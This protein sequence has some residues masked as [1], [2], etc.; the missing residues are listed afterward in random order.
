MQIPFGEI[1]ET[2]GR[3]QPYRI[4]YNSTK[5]KVMSLGEEFCD[6]YGKDCHVVRKDMENQQEN[7]NVCKYIQERKNS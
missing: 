1:Q 6:N 3:Q 7:G 2:L 5:F 4:T